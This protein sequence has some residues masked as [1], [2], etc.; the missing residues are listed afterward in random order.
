MVEVEKEK[1]EYE[2][3]VGAVRDVL[4]PLP[5]DSIKKTLQAISHLQPNSNHIS[6]FA[7]QQI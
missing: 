3:L 5:P 2:M 4:L 7:P 1:N 6:L